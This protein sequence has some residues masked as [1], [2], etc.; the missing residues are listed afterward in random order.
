LQALSEKDKVRGSAFC[1]NFIAHFEKDETLDPLPV[2]K[3]EATFHR[4]E[5]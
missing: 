1:K 5:S 3:D 2:F 4:V